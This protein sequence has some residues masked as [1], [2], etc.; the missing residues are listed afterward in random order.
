MNTTSTLVLLVSFI[1][2]GCLASTVHGQESGNDPPQLDVFPQ[3]A[4]HERPVSIRISGLRPGEEVTLLAEMANYGNADWQAT[5]TFRADSDGI[6]DP[7]VHAPV[8]GSYGDVD[9]MG[10]F[11]SMTR[12]DRDEPA[13]RDGATSAQ[14]SGVVQPGEPVLVTVTAMAEGRPKVADTVERLFADSDVERRPVLEEGIV[15]TLFV[16]SDSE[17]R[18]AIIVPHGGGLCI[19]PEQ[20]AASLAAYGFVTLALQYCGADGLP[21]DFSSEIPLEYFETVIRWLGGRAEVAADRIGILGMSTGGVVALQVAAHFP[22]IRAVV[23][24]KSSGLNSFNFTYGGA[25]LPRLPELSVTPTL[26]DDLTYQ[27]P[28]RCKPGGDAE[29]WSCFDRSLLFLYRVTFNV[30]TAPHVLAQAV[31]PVERINGPVL[32][33]SGI[34]DLALPATLLSE[35]AYKRLEDTRFAFPYEHIAFPG[36]GHRLGLPNLPRTDDTIFGLLLGG[37]AKDAAAANVAFW[38]RTIAF[39]QTHLGPSQQ[40]R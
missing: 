2:T 26:Q 29:K 7:G 23:S 31:I 15:G 16:P 37:N 38:P 5:A 4:L 39:L 19:P 32:L 8:A 24:I 13:G 6:V 30:F 28:P 10:L 40:E 25:P 9:A 1:V 22:E 36:A 12:V 20:L 11:W 33:I 27:Q 14:F 21:E 34:G 17:S 3:R 18:A 35:I